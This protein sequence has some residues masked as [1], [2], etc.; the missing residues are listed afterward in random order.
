VRPA[1]R[2]YD[3]AL[4]YF[5]IFFEADEGIAPALPQKPAQL[6]RVIDGPVSQIEEEL[7]SVRT[8]LRATIE[9]YETHV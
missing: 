2:E 5:L 6:M 8:Q 3:P 4:G 9:Q 1:L 7:S